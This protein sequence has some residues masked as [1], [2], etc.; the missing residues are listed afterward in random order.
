[1]CVRC[2]LNK[3][4]IL[5]HALHMPVSACINNWT[6]N[7]SKIFIALSFQPS[8]KYSWLRD[9]LFSGLVLLMCLFNYGWTRWQLNSRRSWRVREGKN[10]IFWKIPSGTHSFSLPSSHLF[11]CSVSFYVGVALW[12]LWCASQQGV[13]SSFCGIKV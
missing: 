8:A 2:Q 13:F 11:V 5:Y 3:L 1:M 4:H 12:W 9:F 10:S 7:V 6:K